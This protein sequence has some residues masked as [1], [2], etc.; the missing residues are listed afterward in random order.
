MLLDSAP[1][2]ASLEENIEQ[3][4]DSSRPAHEGRDS[5]EENVN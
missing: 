2:S 1:A 3:L 4:L 5:L